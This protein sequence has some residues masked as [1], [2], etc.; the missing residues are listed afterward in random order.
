MCRFGRPPTPQRSLNPLAFACM[1]D[2]DR[3]AL[4]KTKFILIQPKRPQQ[5][6]FRERRTPIPTTLEQTPPAL[7]HLPF[8]YFF[9]PPI[10][11][12][13][14]LQLLL[15]DIPTSL[16][17]FSLTA[18]ILTSPSMASTKNANAQGRDFRVHLTPRQVP[19]QTSF[20]PSGYLTYQKLDESHACLSTLYTRTFAMATEGPTGR[21]EI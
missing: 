18:L 4:L 3:F 7:L 12:S 15:H 20:P 2:L 5:A 8:P 10:F 11:A 14:L 9:R 6:A 16:K 21:G 19:Q 13:T 17:A 1:L